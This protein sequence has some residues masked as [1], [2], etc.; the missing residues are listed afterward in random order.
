VFARR[1][2]QVG[3]IVLISAVILGA[4]L[5]LSTPRVFLNQR[6]ATMSIREVNLAQQNYLAQHPRTGYACNLSD[7]SEQGAV[8][9]VLASGTKAGYHFEIQCPQRSAQNPKSFTIT[10]VPLNPGVTGQY[11]LCADQ[12]GEVWYSEHGLVSDCLA[13]R[14]QVGRKYR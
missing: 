9:G 3:L 12:S 2:F 10:A 7:L 4:F 6:R 11:A 8:D 14:K 13:M 1:S 5:P